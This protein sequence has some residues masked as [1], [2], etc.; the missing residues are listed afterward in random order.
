[1]KI[2]PYDDELIHLGGRVYYTLFADCEG[3]DVFTGIF[4]EHRNED[5]SVCCRGTITFDVEENEELPQPKWE[6][7]SIEPLTLSPSINN[8]NCPNKLHGWII[9]GE[10]TTSPWGKKQQEPM[11]CGVTGNTSLSGSE[12]LGS[13][14]SEAALVD[15]DVN[16]V[17]AGGSH[18]DD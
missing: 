16:A 4:M 14:P 13:N 1:M 11:P 12:V 18:S 5:E 8:T 2:D 3:S 6:V 7:E 10:W 15:K 17:P 9:D